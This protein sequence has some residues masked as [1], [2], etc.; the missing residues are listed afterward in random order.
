[1]KNVTLYH[2]TKDGSYTAIE[3]VILSEAAA[4]S[5]LKDYNSEYFR[6]FRKAK[7][8]ALKYLRNF[9]RQFKRAIDR[10]N[11]TLETQIIVL[12]YTNN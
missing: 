8:D 9:I 2:V 11:N 7:N 6:T 3:K 12:D 4:K 10:L 5:A 1:M